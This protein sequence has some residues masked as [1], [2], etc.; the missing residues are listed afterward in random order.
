MLAGDMQG[1][2]NKLHTEEKRESKPAAP[3]EPPKKEAPVKEPEKNAEPQKSGGL[4]KSL[5]GKK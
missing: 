5:F 1:A 3:K 4:L 2:M